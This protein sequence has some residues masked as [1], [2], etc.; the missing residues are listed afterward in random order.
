MTDATTVIAA[1]T[2][3]PAAAPAPG[4]EINVSIINYRT[5]EMTLRCLASLLKTHDDLHLHVTVVD[6]ASGDGS[7]ERIADWIAAQ[8]AGTPVTLIRS[9]RNTGF[10]GGHNL[11]MTAQPSARFHLILNSDALVRPGTL[12]ALLAAAQAHPDAGLLAPRLEWDDGVPQISAFRRHSPL[13][14]L[15]RGAAT[16]PVTAL[17]RR[18]EVP[19]PLPPAPAEIA[20]VSFACVL[21]RAEA[22]AQVGPMDE[23][24]FLYFEDADHCARLTRAGWRIVQVPEA[25]VVH[26]RGGSAPV[27]SLAA[28]R[29]RLPAYWYASRTRLLYRLHGRAGLLAANLAWHFGRGIAQAR[30]LVGRPVPPAVAREARDIWTN[31]LDPLGD[32][33]RPEA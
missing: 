33:R 18:W 17:L 6:N 7:G 11:G 22:A 14:E 1:A 31:F 4:P 10:S 29:K 5:A 16:G 3:R 8:P 12:R 25:R 20:W 27:K 15:I 13:S 2:T 19:L 28:A 30:R 32:P 26:L 21:L 23:G 24:Y 9:A